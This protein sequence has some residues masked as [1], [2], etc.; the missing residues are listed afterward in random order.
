MTDDRR[1]RPAFSNIEHRTL[2]PPAGGN[3]EVRMGSC[4]IAFRAFLTNSV[5]SSLR[6]PVADALWR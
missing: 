2:N 1:Q 3:I 6:I 4:V 5:L